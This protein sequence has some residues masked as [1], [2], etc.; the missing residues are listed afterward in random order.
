MASRREIGE[1]EV[2]AAEIQIGLYQRDSRFESER[3]PGWTGAIG[4]TSK[5]AA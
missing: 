4:S 3:L 2:A 1:K 5:K